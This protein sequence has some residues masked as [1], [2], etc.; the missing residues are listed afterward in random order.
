MYC[1]S[2]YVQ[3]FKI[4]RC[5]KTR[6]LTFL[7]APIHDPYL[8]WLSN[9]VLGLSCQ[10]LKGKLKA[11]KM[12][13]LSPSTAFPD[14]HTMESLPGWDLTTILA[15]PGDGIVKMSLLTDGIAVHCYNTCQAT[16]IFNSFQNIRQMFNF[17]PLFPSLLNRNY[18]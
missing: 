13:K 2:K 12:R 8:D 17:F 5:D 10:L 15:R 4:F 11:D 6:F 16:Q 9:N 18:L 14:D 1:R 3:C 7:L